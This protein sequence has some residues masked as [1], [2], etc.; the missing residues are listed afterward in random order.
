MLLLVTFSAKGHE[1]GHP[2]T[3]QPLVGYVMDIQPSMLSAP[4]AL[5]PSL[6]ALAGGGIAPVLAF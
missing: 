2:L 3:A 4:L 6:F 1:V 5:V